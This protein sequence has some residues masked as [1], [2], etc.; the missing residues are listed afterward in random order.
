MLDIPIALGAKQL[1]LDTLNSSLKKEKKN[2]KESL[3]LNEEFSNLCLS[4]KIS[5]YNRKLEFYSDQLTKIKFQEYKYGVDIVFPLNPFPDNNLIQYRVN[6]LES[7]ISKLNELISTK[8]YNDDDLMMLED[9]LKCLYL[10][11]Y[12]TEAWVNETLDSVQG[13]W[14]M[15]CGIVT[16]IRNKI[17]VII[18]LISIIKKKIR[19]YRDIRHFFRIIFRF[20]FKNMNDESDNDDNILFLN[21]QLIISFKKIQ[22]ESQNYQRAA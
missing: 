9:E 12:S 22:N 11:K 1:Q 6:H 20:R 5:N 2:L 21:K 13:F 7:I 18:I 14:G 19:C 15:L 10:P 16:G 8:D 3:A 17:C 4:I